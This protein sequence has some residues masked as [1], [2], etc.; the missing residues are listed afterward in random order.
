MVDWKQ[1]NA[2]ETWFHY[3]KKW[4]WRTKHCGRAKN[5]IVYHLDEKKKTQKNPPKKTAPAAGV[6]TIYKFCF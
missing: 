2:R 6:S 5:T 1:D 3:E 4:L